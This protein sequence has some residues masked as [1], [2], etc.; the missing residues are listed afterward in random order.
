MKVA[1]RPAESHDLPVV[2]ALA[3]V[4]IEELTPNRGGS[5]WSQVE[6]RQR[7]VAH[8]FAEEIKNTST[9]VLL[10]TMDEVVVGYAV[11]APFEGHDG[12]T[13]ARITDLYV[14][15]EARGVGVGECLM[16]ALVHWAVALGATGIDALALPG[17]RQTKNFFEA[18]G[19]VARALIVHRSL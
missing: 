13:I 12:R 7:P 18:F 5:V 9:I 15:K 11:A 19:L 3:L 1:A 16:E 14:M 8:K 4:A 17:D 2:A 6:A 10:G